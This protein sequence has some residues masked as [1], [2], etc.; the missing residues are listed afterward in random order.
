MLLQVSPDVGV[1]LVA[2]TSLVWP[3]VAGLILLVRSEAR[4]TATRVFARTALLALV[5]AGAFALWAVALLALDGTTRAMASLGPQ[6][7]A[8]TCVA[9]A[10][11]CGL[12]ALGSRAVA[13]GANGV[14]Q[15]GD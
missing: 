3:A 15:S 13:P 4:V 7:G 12:A 6:I 14:A 11:L 2:A 8:A 9:G 5:V 10:V 1:L